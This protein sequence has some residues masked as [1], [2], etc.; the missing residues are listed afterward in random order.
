MRVSRWTVGAALVGLVAMAPTPGWALATP[1]TQTVTTMVTALCTTTPQF[2]QVPPPFFTTVP[3]TLTVPIRVRAGTSF[4]AQLSVGF[5]V[6]IVVDVGGARLSAAPGMTPASGLV[7][8]P[9]GSSSI[10]GSVTFTASGRA[11]TLSRWRL[12]F[13]GQEVFVGVEVAQTCVPTTDT[14]LAST[15]IIGAGPRASG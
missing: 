6:S 12:E 14:V 4:D 11:G 13:F 5:P 9:A 15:R 8:V 3:V 10:T 7:T 2:P 1:T